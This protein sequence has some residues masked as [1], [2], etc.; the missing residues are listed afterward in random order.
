MWTDSLM[1]V[2]TPV[3]EAGSPVYRLG[4]RVFVRNRHRGR[5]ERPRA[6]TQLL[7]SHISFP[8]FP[9]LIHSFSVAESAGPSREARG[10]ATPFL[11]LNSRL[12]APQRARADLRRVQD[13]IA[14]AFATLVG[15]FLSTL[16][17]ISVVHSTQHRTS[18]HTRGADCEES[19]SLGP[20]HVTRVAPG[21]ARPRA[22]CLMPRN[23]DSLA[24]VLE[25]RLLLAVHGVPAQRPPAAIRWDEARVKSQQARE[26]CALEC[27]CIL[28]VGAPTVKLD[29]SNFPARPTQVELG[30]AL[31][32]RAETL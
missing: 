22:N 20:A 6:F 29:G 18:S 9:V 4:R 26:Y 32:A 31:L 16:F 7:A 21:A 27:W 30:E 12:V 25:A 15:D 23:V 3:R 17:R 28:C 24:A 2:L 19:K 11:F 10:N 13:L 1:G 5:E 14:A 8:H